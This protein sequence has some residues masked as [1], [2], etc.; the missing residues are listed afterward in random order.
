MGTALGSLKCSDRCSSLGVALRCDGNQLANDVLRSHISD[1]RQRL[2]L[3]QA[4]LE[5]KRA[6]LCNSAR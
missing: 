1:G 6:S 3:R 4:R 2:G 5:Y